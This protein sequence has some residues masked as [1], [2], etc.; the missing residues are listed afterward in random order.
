M[1]RRNLCVLL[2]VR[3]KLIGGDLP[4]RVDAVVPDDDAQGLTATLKMLKGS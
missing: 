3:G 1:I 4:D 2:V